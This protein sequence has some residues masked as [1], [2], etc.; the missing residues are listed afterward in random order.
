MYLEST[1]EERFI[2]FFEIDILKSLTH[3]MLVDGRRNIK[4]NQNK[5]S[6][7]ATLLDA[8]NLVLVPS[9]ILKT[10]ETCT[11]HITTT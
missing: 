11:L 4:D 5:R 7:F 6:Q 2:K 8:S 3:V 10:V 1:E 9:T